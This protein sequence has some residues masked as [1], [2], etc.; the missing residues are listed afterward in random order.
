MEIGSTWILH[1]NGVSHFLQFE[2]VD[3]VHE[4]NVIHRDI[5]P[6]NMLLNDKGVVKVIDFNISE[7]LKKAYRCYLQKEL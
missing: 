3:S 1:T 4:S 5:K 2:L 7:V 6:E